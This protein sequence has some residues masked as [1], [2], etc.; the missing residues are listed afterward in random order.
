MK[1]SSFF[2]LIL[3][4]CAL[5][6]SC[7]SLSSLFT[8]QRYTV[9]ISRD[10]MAPGFFTSYE[11]A[12]FFLKQNPDAN[13]EEV[14]E[15]AFYYVYEGLQEGVNYTV[16]FAQMCLETGFLKF[17][18]LVTPDMHNYCGLG[19]IDK[20]NPGASFETMQMGVRAHIQ[21]LQAYATKEDQKLNNPVID[22]RYDWP[23]KSKYIT[24]IQGLAGNWATDPEYSNKL[25]SLIKKIEDFYNSRN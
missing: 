12:D 2:A 16:A 21:H 20:D 7:V 14:Q 17:G 9:K 1:K 8:K 5:C 3:V 24:N 23:H 6:F 25:E 15:L 10:I 13:E 18:N 19:S 22:P 4:F 11:L